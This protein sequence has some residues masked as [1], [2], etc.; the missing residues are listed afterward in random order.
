[1]SRATAIVEARAP[2][3]R[4]LLR[5]LQVVAAAEFKLKYAGSALGY[6]WSVLRPLALFT[7]LYFVFG[8]VF[9]LGAI[10]EFYAVALLIGIVLF[11]FFSDATNLGMYSL[12]ARESLLRKLRFPRMV[13]PTA[14]TLTAGLTFLVN[15]TVVAVF[16]ASKGV[17]PQLDWLLLVPLAL[18]LYVFTLGMTLLL[19]TAFVWL[20]DIAQVWELAVQLLLY[21]S[22][23]IYPIGF[24]PEWARNIAFLNPFTQILQDV[25]AI[26]LYED[27]PAN[28]ITAADA[29]G[30]AG[31]LIPIAIAVGVFVLGVAV[32]K[33]FEP[34]FAE[35]V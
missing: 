28:K 21:A 20:R 6:V 16:V 15:S 1:M 10:S 29:L 31:H 7:V 22:P 34:W 26:V 8:R 9:K 3:L 4:H 32:F 18:E 14:A 11:T 5:I 25:R 19:A 33:R 24:L 17:V 12:V 13:V 27:V 23:V 35:R 2:S 30:A